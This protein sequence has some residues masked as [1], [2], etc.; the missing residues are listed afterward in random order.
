[1]RKCVMVVA[2]AKGNPDGSAVE[3]TCMGTYSLAAK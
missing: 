1:M 3:F 2:K